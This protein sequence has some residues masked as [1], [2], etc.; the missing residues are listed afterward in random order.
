MRPLHFIAEKGDIDTARLFLGY[1]ADPNAIDEEYR[2]TP[3]GWTARCG[4]ADFIR[5]AL[6]NG[7]DPTPEVPAWS[8]PS[9]WA[10]RRGHE[11]VAGMLESHCAT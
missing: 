6:A 9:A 1:G 11:D 5:F 3:L 10:R 7:F 8:A 2:T 4:Q